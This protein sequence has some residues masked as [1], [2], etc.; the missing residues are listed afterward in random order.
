MSKK[1]I[2]KGQSGMATPLTSLS[3]QEILNYNNSLLKQSQNL[4]KLQS[5]GVGKV[6]P[7]TNLIP[8]SGSLTKTT[9]STPKMGAPSI[10]GALG[11]AADTI[12]S[13]FP[14]KT[15]DSTG[16]GLNAA[17]T[18]VGDTMSSIPTPVTQI[19]GAAM[20]AQSM[21]KKMFDN[22]TGGKTSIENPTITSDKIMNSN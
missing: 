5:K 8:N 9:P 7:S 10:A 16:K 19:I 14:D 18:T 4:S 6:Q 15:T 12:G 20:K 21:S 13:F 22:L 1:L 2:P 11:S 17:H 3:I